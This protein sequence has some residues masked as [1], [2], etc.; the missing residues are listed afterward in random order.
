MVF[1]IVT[2]L[3]RR[4]ISY[5]WR[6]LSDFRAIEK[7]ECETDCR[8]TGPEYKLVEE[9][10]EAACD[11]KCN[12]QFD[13]DD[14]TFGKNEFNGGAGFAADNNE[15]V[16]ED[17]YNDKGGQA[18]LASK[19]GLR[20]ML[21]KARDENLDQQLD[22]DQNLQE[23][24]KKI[25]YNRLDEPLGTAAAKE[26]DKSFKIVCVGLAT[27][28]YDVNKKRRYVADNTHSPKKIKKAKVCMIMEGDGYNKKRED[29]M[30][31]KKDEIVR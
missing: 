14:V 21:E 12:Q 4:I 10:Q 22:L 17:N 20:D 7:R 13:D 28:S 26:D 29:C 3:I 8:K 30:I 23:K 11:K 16:D 27:P 19:A 6:S 2:G 15:V 18:G 31:R 24:G 25:A 9:G 1:G 5:G